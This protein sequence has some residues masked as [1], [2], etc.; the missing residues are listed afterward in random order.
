MVPFNCKGPS[1]GYSSLSSLK[2]D[3]CVSGT[4]INGS[5]RGL[6]GGSPVWSCSKETP[7]AQLCPNR[8]RLCWWLQWQENPS[9]CIEPQMYFPLLHT[10]PDWG[11]SACSDEYT[12]KHTHHFLFH[13]N[14]ISSQCNVDGVVATGVRCRTLLMILHRRHQHIIQLAFRWLCHYVGIKEEWWW[15]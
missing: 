10:H 13:V 1:L 9:S 2:M 7:P 3:G 14:D 6:A 8:Q 12:R 4:L 11:F 5:T 15:K